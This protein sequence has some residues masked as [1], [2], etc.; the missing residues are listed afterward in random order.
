MSRQP[1]S[2]TDSAPS[3]P[4]GPAGPPSLPFWP[5]A[6]QSFATPETWN[7]SS[8]PWIPPVAVSRNWWMSWSMGNCRLRR[9]CLMR[10]LC[11]WKTGIWGR[12]LIGL[13]RLS[14][15][16]LAIASSRVRLVWLGSGLVLSFW[17]FH[18]LF[19]LFCSIWIGSWVEPWRSKHWLSWGPMVCLVQLGCSLWYIC[20]HWI[21]GFGSPIRRGRFCICWIPRMILRIRRYSIRKNFFLWIMCQWLGF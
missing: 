20:K 7:N 19:L 14:R 17:G 4:Q 15:V 8:P 21:L 5:A 13:R 11:C 6:Y 18:R 12:L 10:W 1:S 2:W 3:A 16:W 9:H